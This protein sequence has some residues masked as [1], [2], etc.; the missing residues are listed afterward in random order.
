M[1]LPHKQHS[2]S[3]SSDDKT[4]T[5][6][7]S[8]FPRAPSISDEWIHMHTRM[9]NGV[10][11]KFSS[12]PFISPVFSARELF[13]RWPRRMYMQGQ[14]IAHQHTR[15]HQK[16][17]CANRYGIWLIFMS[18][19]PPRFRRHFFAFYVLHSRD[20][21]CSL[22]CACPPGSRLSA[23]RDFLISRECHFKV[24]LPRKM[25]MEVGKKISNGNGASLLLYHMR[26]ESEWIENVPSEKLNLLFQNPKNKQINF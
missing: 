19:R 13:K 5:Q 9:D 22:I 26:V 24:S 18:L 6:P 17:I 1:G 4:A 8:L 16:R 23:Q 12:Q 7:L 10:P 11:N 14:K 25:L 21:N 2:N 3:F 15:T 20:S